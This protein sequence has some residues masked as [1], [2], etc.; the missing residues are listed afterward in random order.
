MKESCKLRKHIISAK[1]RA[2]ISNEAI[3]NTTSREN[4]AEFLREQELQW[5]GHTERVDNE[6]ALKT[7]KKF[8]VNGSKKGRSTKRWKKTC[9]LKG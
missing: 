6:K 8:V 3:S 5:L 9:S 2:G 4:I 1:K 7:I